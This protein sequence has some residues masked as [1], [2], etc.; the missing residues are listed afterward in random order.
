MPYPLDTAT[1]L[2]AEISNMWE[3][4]LVPLAIILVFLL[5]SGGFMFGVGGAATRMKIILRPAT[6]FVS[7]MLYSMAFHRE[8]AR[9]LHWSDARIGTSILGAAAGIL[10]AKRWFSKWHDHSESKAIR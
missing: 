1:S 9:L 10:L 8:I 2:P 6:V 3:K 7:V 5:L 4:L